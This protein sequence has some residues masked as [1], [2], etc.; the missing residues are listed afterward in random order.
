[1]QYNIEQFLESKAIYLKIPTYHVNKG[2]I[3]KHSSSQCVNPLNNVGSAT[4]N[5]SNYH[6]NVT[7]AS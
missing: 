5:S 3:K 7:S 6:A 2:D 1:M 4:E